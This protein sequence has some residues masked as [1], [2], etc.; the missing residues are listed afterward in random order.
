MHLRDANGLTA[1]RF[2]KITISS[3]AVTISTMSLPNGTQQTAYSATRTA[4][5][6]TPPYSWTIASG[7]LP[8]G[9]SLNSSSGVISG[10]PQ[11][12]GTSDFTVRVTDSSSQSATKPLSI[13]SPS[14]GGGTETEIEENDPSIVYT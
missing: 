12:A 13:V 2:L 5:G 6:G 9:L 10:T 1:S 7:G 4:T 11:S 14:G 3:N 8:T